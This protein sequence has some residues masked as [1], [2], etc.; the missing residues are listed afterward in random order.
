MTSTAYNIAGARY[1]QLILVVRREY[2]QWL[3]RCDCGQYTMRNL[4]VIKKR[5]RAR[6]PVWCIQCEYLKGVGYYTL[7]G[8]EVRAIRA[9][10]VLLDQLAPPPAPPVLAPPVPASPAPIA[11]QAAKPV[12]VAPP[13][14]VVYPSDV[15]ISLMTPD[16][17]LFKGHEY[18][19]PSDVTLYST[20]VFRH[21][22]LRELD[23][24]LEARRLVDFLGLV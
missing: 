6:N 2:G 17:R 18:L 19:G 14:P 15:D 1:G 4:S 3:C 11:R 7:A 5:A 12:L 16:I 13:V 22:V 23:Y 21:S 8:E 9:H 10:A 20:D 24:S